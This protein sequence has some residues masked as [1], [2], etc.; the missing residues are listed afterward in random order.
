[1]TPLFEALNEVQVRDTA[2]VNLVR[3]L[4]E[5]IPSTP[6]QDI[7]DT[8]V[9]GRTCHIVRRTQEEVVITFNI[10]S[11]S[12]RLM[13]CHD[14]DITNEGSYS[15]SERA[16]ASQE[17]TQDQL[18]EPPLTPEHTQYVMA[19]VWTTCTATGDFEDFG[20]LEGLK[21]Y[22]SS[23]VASSRP[24]NWQGCRETTSGS[25]G[26]IMAIDVS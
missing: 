23:T 13:Q 9:N 4:L 16:R 2:E 14:L 1:M 7:P 12:V 20:Y 5:A 22:G 24:S 11:R 21:F 26:E 10:E 18:Q 6:I 15:R 25:P 17:Q 19:Q 8:Q 3:S